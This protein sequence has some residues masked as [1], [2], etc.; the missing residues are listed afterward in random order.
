VVQRAPARRR[1]LALTMKAKTILVNGIALA[2]VRERLPMALSTK[3][4][5]S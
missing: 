4:P 3:D 1:P 2:A 5:K